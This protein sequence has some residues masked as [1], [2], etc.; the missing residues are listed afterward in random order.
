M[1]QVMSAWASPTLIITRA[2]MHGEKCVCVCVYHSPAFVLYAHV[3]ENCIVYSFMYSTHSKNFPT[4][5][6][7]NLRQ[8][9]TIYQQATNRKWQRE[10]ELPW[11]VCG[12]V[13][14]ISLVSSS[15]C[16]IFHVPYGLRMGTNFVGLKFCIF[17]E[18][19]LFKDFNFHGFVTGVITAPFSRLVVRWYLWI[20]EQVMAKENNSWV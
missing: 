12:V 4:T 15:T 14:D 8:R 7:S 11:V 16:A 2:S 17:A 3:P 9:L 6:T 1:L 20:N 19:S 10:A 5:S 18:T 13:H